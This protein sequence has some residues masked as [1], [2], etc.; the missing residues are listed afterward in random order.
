MENKDIGNFFKLQNSNYEACLYPF[1]DCTN[2]PINAHS[3]QNAR[4]FDILNED[5]HLIQIRH[6]FTKE[7]NVIIEFKSIGRN[8]ASTFLGLC[9]QHD[10][11]LFDQIDKNPID[12][13]NKEQLFLIAY[14]SVLKEYH[15]VLTGFVK[16]QTAYQEKIKS[17]P[18]KTFENAFTTIEWI[19]RSH[20][21]NN[22]KQKFDSALKSR[23]FSYIKHR[24][25]E[26]N[27]QTP[28][29]ACSQLF[30]LDN[31]IIEDDVARIVLNIIPV[32]N[33]KTIV[34]F[35]SISPE[36][37]LA[38]DFIQKCFE[39][40]DS[41]RKYQLSKLVIQNC[42]NFFINPKFFNSWSQD[43]KQKISDYYI[44]TIGDHDEDSPEFYLFQN[45]A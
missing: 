8:D 30:S 13:S 37:S 20:S 26:L 5:N 39:G 29:I 10:N 9:S 23:D 17:N 2:K 44:N 35:S 32:E 38:D 24:I 18:H 14:R 15:A 31:Y 42:E 43:K 40:N 41:S 22:Y 6:R 28:S 19:E 27:N 21:T 34:I 36:S 33:D 1:K 12:L 25:I 7:L 3:I 11:S 45:E 16:I 4:T